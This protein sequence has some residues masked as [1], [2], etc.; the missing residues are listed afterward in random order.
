VG[1]QIQDIKNIF[2]RKKPMNT[3]GSIHSSDLF[4]VILERE[5]ARSE[6]T[7]Q[8]FSLVIF[9][10]NSR[11]GIDTATLESLGN[12]ITQ[13]IRK[14]DEIGWYDGNRI[15]TILTGTSAE[16]ACRFVEIVKKRN[17][18]IEP[19][20]TC[21]V[22]SYPFSGIHSD[23]PHE[24]SKERQNTGT[25]LSSSKCSAER[26]ETLFAQPIP[27]WKRFFDFCGA[28]LLLILLS[29]VFLLITLFIKIV[30]PGPVFFRQERLG[31]M[32]KP[33]TL[34][35][36]R[37]M[38]VNNDTEIHRQHIK[39]AIESDTPIAKLDDLNDNRIIPFGKLLRYSCLDELP[40]LLNVLRGDMSLIGPRP[41]MH[42][43]A[44]KLLQWQTRRYDILPGMS[45]LWQ[46]SGK[47]R[48]TFK[49][50]TRFDIRYSS[51]ISPGLD[52]KILLLTVP[53]ILGMVFDFLTNQTAI[54]Q[55][56]AKLVPFHRDTPFWR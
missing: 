24:F 33:F 42:F 36:F 27:I 28:I 16:G 8:I 39:N 51:K 26:L 18:E 41:C 23:N 45:G 40:Q 35:K 6:R 15:G 19:N 50:M 25:D 10:I 20:L 3:L 30:S 56:T 52:A 21:T 31:H 22:Y 29:P 43:E 53:A 5:R 4:R 9:G 14:S 11:N 32:G 34:W 46:V 17:E 54:K 38:H 49:E 7:G 12:D 2:R 48:T 55:K 47:N 37:T 1:F 13:K 44:E